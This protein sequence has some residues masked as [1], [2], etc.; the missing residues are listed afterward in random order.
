MEWKNNI[1]NILDSLGEGIIT[2]D[3]D[4]R[5]TYANKAV[6]RILGFFRS[7]IEGRI[8]KNV[9]KSD[10][11]MNDCPIAR[12]IMEK[13][14]IYDTIV[15]L[16]NKFKGKI[17]VKLNVALLKEDKKVVG[18]IISFTPLESI[19]I[20]DFEIR[21]EDGYYGI[22]G[23]SKVM[24]EIYTLIEEI[25]DSDATVLVQGESGTGKELVADAIQKT[26]LRKDK[27]Y[28]KVN[29]A[30]Y[31]PQ[32]LSSEL[33]GHVKGAFTGAIKN[34]A[35]RFEIAD[36]GT[37]FLDEVGEMPQV[38]QI[39]LL[40]VLQE[41]TFERL[42]ES[43]T[44]KVN[45]RVIAATNKDLEKEIARGNF[46]ED[47]YFRLNV[48]PITIPPLRERKEDIPLLVNHF[49]NKFS[50]LYKKNVYE[51]TDNALDLLM[52][53]DWPG[54]VREL[55]NSIEYAFVRTK[56]G[57]KIDE[58]KLPKR[59]KEKITCDTDQGKQ[60]LLTHESH[61]NLKNLHEESERKL[62]L[63]LLEK[64]KWN[65]SKVAQE[66]GIGRTTLWRK[67]K[68]LGLDE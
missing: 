10:K 6:E 4:F 3:K 22:V 37:L 24:R 66:L 28:V 56:A 19:K 21:K 17:P 54:N 41:G 68:R 47:L 5:I 2:I 43:I 33:F 58:C 16:E 27:P 50:L 61:L 34:R 49:L 25:A 38:M 26:S 29:C 52:D 64:Y 67:L 14:N 31:P 55:E 15:Y 60:N 36:G 62:I 8:C 63:S 9:L 30:V 59:I 42:G 20:E 45:V 51:V 35:G 57:G 39:Q 7:E 23:K 18:G 11:C 53:Y 65:K 1:E 40:R 44:R 12:V 32:L 46:R 13:R 48:I